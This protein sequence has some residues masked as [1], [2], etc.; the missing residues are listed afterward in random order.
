MHTRL[1]RFA[2]GFA[3]VA[4]I[5]IHLQVESCIHIAHLPLYQMKNLWKSYADFVN[6]AAY[7]IFNPSTWRGTPTKEGGTYFYP[8]GGYNAWAE[9][10]YL[11]AFNELPEVNAVINLTARSMSSGII[12]SVNS[13]V[14]PVENDPFLKIIAQPNW[15]QAEK[16]WRMQTTLFHEIFG[17]EYIYALFPLGF[18]AN[19]TTDLFTLPPPLVCPEY[20]D[21]Q[22]FFVH[23][24]RNPPKIEYS[25]DYAGQ[26]ALID[27]EQIIHMNDNRVTIEK[28]NDKHLLRGQSKMEALTSAINNLYLAYE[29]RGVILKNRGALGILSNAGKDGVGAP[30]I[31]DPKEIED[32][33]KHY[34]RKYGGLN[35]QH[36]LI[37]SSANLK[38]QQMSVNPDKLGLYDET[39]ECFFKV[40]D[41]WQTPIELFTRKN[42][43]TYENQKQARKGFYIENIIPKGNEWIGGLNGK[44]Y[45][46]S[47]NKLIMDFNHLH[48][49][50]EEL[51]V[52]AEAM[53]EMINNLSALFADKQ[54][55]SQ[56]YREEL[57]KIGLGDGK[58]VVFMNDKNANQQE[59]ETQRA[60]A[61]LRGSVG[62]V[63][64][65]LSIQASVSTGTTTR[66]AAISMLTIVFG[67]TDVQAN[68]LLG[69]PAEAAPAEEEAVM[70]TED[71]TK[72]MI[73]K[74]H[75]EL[76]GK[77]IIII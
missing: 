44:F 33:Q 12:K 31:M 36:Q 39:E 77:K 35:S 40:L 66:D 55:S 45:E 34:A 13:R 7:N 68:E 5:G 17:N 15:F 37:I 25:I 11:N 58:V 46:E 30:M 59:V 64:G 21:M 74:F 76:T 56:E 14:K 2:V 62:G 26:K 73:V 67:F 16:E 69:E 51:K 22:P 41:A 43:S 8:I 70:P 27:P 32:L 28:V 57:Q 23:T 61:A 71:E 19:R 50:Q 24:K 53:G 75:E 29:S 63:Q 10:N 9:V 38:W 18:K 4:G 48:I 72:A 60:Q 49:F 65:I 1:R 54:I 3:L 20:K 42:G 52:K 47:N 6:K